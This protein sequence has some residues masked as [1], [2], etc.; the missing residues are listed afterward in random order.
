MDPSLKNKLLNEL[1][2]NTIPFYIDIFEDIAE[3]NDYTFI[4]DRVS[5]IPRSY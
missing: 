2:S 3:N 4:Q 1:K 5:L